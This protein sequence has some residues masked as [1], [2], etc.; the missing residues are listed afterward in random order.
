MGAVFCQS[1]TTAITRLNVLSLSHSQLL[2]LNL[3]HRNFCCCSG[4]RSKTMSDVFI[5][6]ETKVKERNASLSVTVL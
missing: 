5:R 1:W 2:F 3:E 6:R 4:T